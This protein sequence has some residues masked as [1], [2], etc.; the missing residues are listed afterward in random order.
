MSQ[1]PDTRPPTSESE[2]ARWVKSIVGDDRAFRE[3]V[4]RQLAEISVR[5]QS[6]EG[7]MDEHVADDRSKFAKVDQRIDTSEGKSEETRGKLHLILG[8]IA[9]GA[10]IVTAAIGLARLIA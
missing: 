4:I 9:V 6:M 10:F 1:P 8:G 5:L 3:S 2:L 7:K